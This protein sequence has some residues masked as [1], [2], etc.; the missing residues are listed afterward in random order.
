MD[1][2]LKPEQNKLAK[3][4][5]LCKFQIE[6]KSTNFI[7]NYLKRFFQGREVTNYTFRVE[8]NY[9]YEEATVQTKAQKCSQILKE[10]KNFE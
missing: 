1:L 3:Q 9:T 2:H 8:T 6:T 4:K 5:S 7:L 10:Q